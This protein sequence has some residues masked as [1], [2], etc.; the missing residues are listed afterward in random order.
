VAGR[1][2][3]NAP[4]L[5]HNRGVRAALER[6]EAKLRRPGAL[7]DLDRA[8]QYYL[9]RIPE[10]VHDLPA[11]ER[12]R[13]VAEA[14][15]PQR[16]WQQ[17]GEV[18]APEARL[19]DPALFPDEMVYAGHTLALDYRLAPGEPGDGV[20][21]DVPL[22][23][24]A[25]LDA[26]LLAWGVP[27]QRHELLT[28]LIRGLPKALRRP[29]VPAPATAAA[30]LALADTA[31]PLWP[32]TARLLSRHAGHPIPEEA[33]RAVTLPDH[34]RFNLRVLA[35]DGRMLAE[36]RDLAA[37]RLQ[38]RDTGRQALEQSTRDF[39]RRDLRDW[40]LGRLAA[41]ITIER[42]D[43]QHL[44]Y[45]ALADRNGTVTL[46]A[47]EDPV[48][49]EAMHRSGLRRLL[50]RRLA[51]P[52]KPVRKSLVVDREL[53]LLQQPHGP[54]SQLIDDVCDRAVDLACLPRSESLP[55]DREAFDMAYERGRGQLYAVAI[56]LAACAKAVL[57]A[58]RAI[59]SALDRPPSGPSPLSSRGS[60]RRRPRCRTRRSC[61]RS[62]RSSPGSRLCSRP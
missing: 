30:I 2:R 34:L 20:S 43:V 59:Q 8:A 58:A 3:L 62:A 18:L 53:A 31:Q 61:R 42:G 27:G 13:R 7:F 39:A 1:C 23:L 57:Q 49:A 5:A 48:E 12:W 55:R 19:P 17:P 51:D 37:L 25:S 35:D 44:V 36:G 24:L 56:R 6:Q 29:L 16:L 11:F 22:A 4:F 28:T 41:S 9:E 38:L 14:T 26:A 15:L 46:E 32:E 40:D 33:L 60:P 45:P 10:S 54:L 47:F 50:A 52:L 21:L